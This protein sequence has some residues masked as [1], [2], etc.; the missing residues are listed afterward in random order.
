MATATRG[1]HAP[2]GVV[3]VVEVP[4]AQPLH[5][6]PRLQDPG[7][8]R[9]SG[10][11]A[12][13]AVLWQGPG[14]GSG[15]GAGW[16]QALQARRPWVREEDGGACLHEV[17][18]TCP[19]APSPRRP[20]GPGTPR[21]S[22]LRRGR[23][24]TCRSRRGRS[25]SPPSTLGGRVPSDI[26]RGGPPDLRG[27]PGHPSVLVITWGPCTRW[28]AGGWELGVSW[29]LGMMMGGRG[30]RPR[31]C[32]LGFKG[33]PGRPR[34][35]ERP[36]GLSPGWW[37]AAITVRVGGRAPAA[38]AHDHGGEGQPA[39]HAVLADGVQ[40]VGGEV[41]VQVAEEHDAAGVLEATGVSELPRGK[42]QSSPA[43]PPP[44]TP[45]THLHRVHPGLQPRRALE[46][47]GSPQVLVPG[48]GVRGAG[49]QV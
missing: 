48:G 11:G 9:G 7:W 1:P 10:L 13:R 12:G 22:C 26:R 31:H 34:G 4:Q 8:R 45:C 43:P 17:G 33:T 15:F 21:C 29:R 16:A 5:L 46:V 27:L 41:D 38:Q 30:G 35:W 28:S 44:R 37:G 32:G 47:P 18:V 14:V 39:L 24:P 36:P 3:V 23:S 25:R 49:G 20:T 42:G 2:P 6:Q 40:D 19:G